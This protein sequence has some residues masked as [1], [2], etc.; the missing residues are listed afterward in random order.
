MTLNLTKTALTAALRQSTTL[1]D[2]YRAAGCSRSTFLK[3]AEKWPPILDLVAKKAK[4][5]KRLRGRNHV[6]LNRTEVVKVVRNARSVADAA[7]KLGVVPATLEAYV[8]REDKSLLSSVWFRLVE[9]GRANR[10][11]PQ[12]E[13]RNDKLLADAETATSYRELAA[14]YDVSYQRVAA[15]I[16]TYGRPGLAADLVARGR[17]HRNDQGREKSPTVVR[18][19]RTIMV[20]A[21]SYAEARREARAAGIG[22]AAFNRICET[23]GLA[24]MGI[25]NERDTIMDFRNQGLRNK[26]IAQAMGIPRSRVNTHVTA[27][28][29]EGEVDPQPVGRPASSTR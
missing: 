18:L 7:G 17:A 14:K 21:R 13:D 11:A 10:G 3:Y 16:E 12:M 4:E 15:I 26:E 1:E 28:I 2:A 29:A 6:E 8:H 23:H 24:P 25:A 19:V 5:G 27:L 22:V 20:D 9:R